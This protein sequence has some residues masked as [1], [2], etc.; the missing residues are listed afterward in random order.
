VNIINNGDETDCKVVWNN[1][2]A[3]QKLKKH[4]ITTLEWNE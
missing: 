4:S 3:V 2:M 1:K